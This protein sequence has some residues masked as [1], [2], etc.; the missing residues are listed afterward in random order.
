MQKPFLF[1][2]RAHRH[3]LVLMHSII[4]VFKHHHPFVP[5]NPPNL[6]IRCAIVIYP[7]WKPAAP[8]CGPQRDSRQHDNLTLFHMQ[9][10]VKIPNAHLSSP[11][12]RTL[13]D[14]VGCGL[15]VVDCGLRGWFCILSSRISNA[16]TILLD[17]PVSS[18]VILLVVGSI[19]KF[20]KQ[21]RNNDEP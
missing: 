6:P 12:Y 13:F 10:I 8:T 11:S 9:H 5:P 3:T 21:C 1:S 4:H 15:W 14:A 18:R 19:C 7:I 16:R 17:Y 2:F 20:S